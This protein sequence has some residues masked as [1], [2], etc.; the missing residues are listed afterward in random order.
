MCFAI[1]HFVLLFGIVVAA[2]LSLNI[3]KILQSKTVQIITDDL[4]KTLPKR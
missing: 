4:I 3:N 1:A 2:V